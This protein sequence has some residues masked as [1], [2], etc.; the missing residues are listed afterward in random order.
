[1]CNFK[2]RDGKALEMEALLA[3]MVEAA[4]DEKGVEVYS[5]HR[6]EENEFW[7]FA[8]LHDRDAMRRHNQTAAVVAFRAEFDNLVA[9]PPRV[10]VTVPVAAIGLELDVDEHIAAERPRSRDAARIDLTGAT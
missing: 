6:G 2:C 7:F 1:M 5:F 8:L 10:S 9:S 3:D 4:L